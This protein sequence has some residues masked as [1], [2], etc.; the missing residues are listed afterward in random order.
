MLIVDKLFSVKFR[1]TWALFILLCVV[2]F[3]VTGCSS[4]NSAKSGD[5]DV[6]ID[7]SWQPPKS[8][9]N[10]HIYV[11][12]VDQ[13]QYPP[14]VETNLLA[15]A[16]KAAVIQ[17]MKKKG[18]TLNENAPGFTESLTDDLPEKNIESVY[19][20]ISPQNALK[21]GTSTK[22][23]EESRNFSD[24]NSTNDG[25]YDLALRGSG[26][27]DG[28]L[29][30]LGSA[31]K[32]VLVNEE[33]IGDLFNQIAK[34]PLQADG[35]TKQ[36]QKQLEKKW[37]ACMRSAGLPQY[38]TIDSTAS[39][40]GNQAFREWPRPVTAQETRVA[41]TSGKCMISTGYL[42]QYSKYRAQAIHALVSKKPGLITEWQR[43]H[44]EQI[45]HAQQQLQH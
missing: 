4:G 27:P 33:K 37:A 13:I 20:Y 16:V 11:S 18:F 19:S 30:C 44:R 25:G 2:T 31:K 6:K 9:V 8:A 36:R 21:W 1:V 22:D 14:Q 26:K 42:E 32:R 17:C 5:S 12:E 3:V 15:A 35:L 45:K 23:F 7:A 34:I 10:S 38:S 29:G 24:Q 41:E 40:A 39:S 43:L 28:D